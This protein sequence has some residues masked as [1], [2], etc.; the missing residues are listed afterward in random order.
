V[1]PAE[2]ERLGVLWEFAYV[3]D[4][5]TFTPDKNQLSKKSENKIVTT[6]LFVFL[7]LQPIAV[8]LSTAR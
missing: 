1:Y 7:A 8:V 3:T 4:V 2:N 6:G 5:V